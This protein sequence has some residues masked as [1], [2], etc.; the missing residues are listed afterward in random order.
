MRKRIALAALTLSLCC[1]CASYHYEDP[2]GRKVDVLKLGFKTEIGSFDAGTRDGD[3]LKMA[4][5][6]ADGSESFKSL[7]ATLQRIAELLEKIYA[8]IASVVK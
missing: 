3:H 8:P 1:G 7:T 4:G 2:A 6:Q 5:V